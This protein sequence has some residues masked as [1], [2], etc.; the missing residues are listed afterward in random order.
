LQTTPGGTS[1]TG[2]PRRF[3][4]QHI[5]EVTGSPGSE[6]LGSENRLGDQHR[7]DPLP[8][9]GEPGMHEQ[10]AN[11]GSQWKDPSPENASTPSRT[12]SRSPSPENQFRKRWCGLFR[13]TR[14][15]GATT[16]SARSQCESTSGGCPYDSLNVGVKTYENSPYAGKV[17]PMTP[18]NSVYWF[19]RPTGLPVS[20][21]NGPESLI[22]LGTIIT[23]NSQSNQ[24]QKQMT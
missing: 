16:H 14:A 8:S 6:V 17:V 10:T 12:R 2:Q 4:L 5:Y 18:G 24:D 21:T 7:T 23:T 22:P 9:F 13:S 15:P 3:R 1:S 20:I 19:S 11:A